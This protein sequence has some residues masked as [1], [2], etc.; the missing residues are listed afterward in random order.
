MSLFPFKHIRE[1]QRQLL[2]DVQKSLESGRAL[3]AHAPTGIGKT[4]AVLSPAVEHSLKH[5]N[6]VDLLRI[7]AFVL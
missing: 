4:V 2:S 3:V 6:T 7:K 1:G 5:G